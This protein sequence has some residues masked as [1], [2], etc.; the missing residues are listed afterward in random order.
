MSAPAD[1]ASQECSWRGAITAA[2]AAAC[3]HEQAAMLL[4]LQR[5]QSHKA[6]LGIMRG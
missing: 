2:V 1:G 4:L 6:V 3:A 5:P